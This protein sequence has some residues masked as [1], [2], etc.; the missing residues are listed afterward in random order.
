MISLDI[1][2]IINW[3]LEMPEM[4]VY[5]WVMLLMTIESSFIPF[6]SEFVVPPAAYLA[7]NQRADIWLVLLFATLGAML[8]AIFNYAIAWWLG[9]PIVYRF[10][11]SRL[12][13][14][15]LIDQEKVERAEKYFDQHGALATLI[16]RLVPVIRQLISIPAG[17]AK[18]HFGKFLFYTCIGAGVWNSILAILGYVLGKTLKPD[19]FMDEIERY[20]T[21]ISD[22]ILIICAIGIGLLIWKA[23]R[24]KA[25]KRRRA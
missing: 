12:G 24:H 9:R 25:Q 15:C 4:Q 21:V 18:M 2:S 1:A 8:G 3:F 13:H 16:G 7:A 14:M 11:N 5:L 6:P 22:A 20:N 17:L 19:M 10:A 23:Y